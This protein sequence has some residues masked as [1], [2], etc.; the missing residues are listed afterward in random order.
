MYF[1]DWKG[2]VTIKKILVIILVITFLVSGGSIYA[3]GN[4]EANLSNLYEASIQMEI[5]KL[6]T[7]TS[8]RMWTTLKYTNAFVLGSKEYIDT[9][10]VDF[11]DEQVRKTVEVIV[12]YKNDIKS[13]VENTN[14]EL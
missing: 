10:I 5:A 8:S 12:D 2:L 9:K 7:A 13:Q 3:K 4:L 6:G 11:R 14:T 1:S